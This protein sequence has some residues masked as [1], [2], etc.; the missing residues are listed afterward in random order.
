M[1]TM[2]V[3]LEIVSGAQAGEIF[4][5]RSNLQV[6]IGRGPDPEIEVNT[7]PLLSELH[8]AFWWDESG[9]RIQDLQ[10]ARGTFLNGQKISQ[11]A[12]RNGDKIVAGQTHFVV[13]VKRDPRIPA[14]V[15]AAQPRGLVMEQLERRATAESTRPE[16]QKTQ[17]RDLLEILRTQPQPLFAILDAARDQKVL[18]S[19]RI[20]HQH[21]QSLYEGPKGEE[22]AEFAPYL[23]ELPSN[24]A[25]IETLVR[26]GW[27]KSWGIFLTSASSFKEVRRHFR[28]FLLVQVEDGRELY[29]RFYDP[30]VLRIFLPTCNAEET[31]TFFGPVGQFLVEAQ[32]AE[33][34]LRF[35][36][37]RG[38][39]A[40]E[41]LPLLP[42][43]P[44]T[45]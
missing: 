28:H 8:F 7:D 9:C 25:L 39:V 16:A 33:T 20:C 45:S 15:P 42:A 37:L 14:V 27:G 24:S 12:V 32:D 44:V 35:S 21:Y 19:L 31:A 17:A 41:S 22:L 34:L 11:A 10:S 26:E 38:V 1:S 6:R 3:S 43:M 40:R 13:C 18:V 30:R 4:P 2:E 5:L 29:F 23:A 36:L